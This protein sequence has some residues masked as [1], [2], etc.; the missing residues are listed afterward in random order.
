MNA[1]YPYTSP[2]K[3]LSRGG[4]LRELHLALGQTRQMAWLWGMVVGRRSLLI[5]D[6][7]TP[8]GFGNPRIFNTPWKKPVSYA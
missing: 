8:I 3:Q 1:D 4:R 2:L 6:L 7:G 5:E